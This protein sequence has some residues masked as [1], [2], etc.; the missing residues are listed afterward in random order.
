MISIDQFKFTGQKVLVRVDFNV[1]LNDDFQVT[2][3]T[4]IRASLPTI[5]KILEGGGSVII[6]SHLDRPNGHE[7]RF[8]NKHIVSALSE[9]L[10]TDVKFAYDTIGEKVRELAGNLFPGEV[11]LLENTRF[12][13]EEKTGNDI[14]ARHLASLSDIYINDAFSTAHR[15]HASTTIVANYFDEHHK[16]FGLL[17][18]D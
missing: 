15:A 9:L 12:Y 5:N 17:M 13:D 8:S 10:G 7:E 4:K 11:L 14:F 3:D 2:D 1:P 6:M 18:A 16:G